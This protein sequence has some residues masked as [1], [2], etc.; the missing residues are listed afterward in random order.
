[1]RHTIK[2]LALGSVFLGM[3]ALAPMPAQALT[4]KHTQGEVTL[5]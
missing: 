4:I 3:L 2:G 5:Q 1:M